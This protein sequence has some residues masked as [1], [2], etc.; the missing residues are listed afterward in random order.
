[1]SENEGDM[2]LVAEIG[3]PVPGEHA[4]AGEGEVVAERGE[5][6]EDSLGA[7]GDGESGD[8]QSLGVEDA[9]G[10]GSGVEIDAAVK[11]VLVG[12]ESH[13]G[14]PVKRVEATHFKCASRTEAMM[15]IQPLQ[16]K[17]PA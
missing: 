17:G 16:Q 9:E 12:V 14:L 10:E 1:V 2:V 4:L 8:D 11:S 6:V 5:G 13:H 15:S 3:E 7:G